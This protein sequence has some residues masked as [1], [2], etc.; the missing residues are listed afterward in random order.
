MVALTYDNE[1]IK[2]KI[3]F[4]RFALELLLIN[5][6][7]ACNINFG[8]AIG[9]GEYADIYSFTINGE[10]FALKAFQLPNTV[11]RDSRFLRIIKEL[12]I[13][14][15]CSAFGLCPTAHN[16]LGFDLIVFDDL[17]FFT[18]EKGFAVKGIRKDELLSLLNT[19]HNLRIIHSDI[20]P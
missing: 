8:K 16:Y 2:V 19:M 3:D 6:F 10:E 5:V 1:I 9:S 14:K 7:S 12:S 15:I 13:M 4:D 11:S 20:K 17:A 18:M